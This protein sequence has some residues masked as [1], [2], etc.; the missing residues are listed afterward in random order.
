[1]NPNAQRPGSCQAGRGSATTRT[2]SPATRPA[3]LVRR[4]SSRLTPL[5]STTR[6]RRSV[7]SWAKDG[8]GA[9]LTVSAAAT[10]GPTANVAVCRAQL[11]IVT[12]A[13]TDAGASA[14]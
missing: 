7:A 11:S 6:T 5:R 4:T 9:P 12:S 1:M 2:G 13:S 3:L 8:P 10:S 14:A